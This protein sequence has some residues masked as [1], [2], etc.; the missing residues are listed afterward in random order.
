M[1]MGIMQPYFLPYLGYWQLLAMVDKYVVLDDVNYI[2]RGW[3]NRNRILINN[4]PTYMTIPLCGASQNKKINELEL[5]NQKESFEHIYKM[6]QQGYHKAP[7]YRNGLTLVESIFDYKGKDLQ[8]FLMHSL[9]RV[10]NYLN[11]HTELLLASDID[12]EKKL[13]GKERILYICEKMGAD[14]YINA[15]GGVKL[16][17]KADFKS[18]GIK[19]HFLKSML[20]EYTQYGDEFVSALSILD[21]LMFNSKSEV[22]QMLQAYTLF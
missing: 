17:D 5:F 18:R 13:R 10:C 12:R 8:G 22:L 9:R 11:I 21:V 19:L 7:E 1:K 16:Y 6:I 4:K 3:I 15:E 14:E 20:P 2:N